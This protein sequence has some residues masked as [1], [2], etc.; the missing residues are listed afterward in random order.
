MCN[1]QVGIFQGKMSFIISHAIAKSDESRA[2]YIADCLPK[3]NVKNFS[4]II[5][6]IDHFPVFWSH[7]LSDFILYAVYVRTYVFSLG[8]R[9]GRNF[10]V[11]ILHFL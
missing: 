10:T 9:Q 7:P 1:T 5:F 8:Q 4:W 11:I 3:E 6:T 2:P